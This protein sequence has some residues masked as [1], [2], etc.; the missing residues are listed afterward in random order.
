MTLEKHDL[1][2]E[3]PEYRDQIHEMKMSNAHFAKLFEAYHE[4][5]HEVHYWMA[6]A[7]RAKSSSS[8]T[9]TGNNTP[10]DC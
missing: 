6:R 10:H 7:A 1:V 5:D 8:E 3:L 2:H 4:I 9:D